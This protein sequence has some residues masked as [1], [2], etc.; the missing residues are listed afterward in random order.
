MTTDQIT[1]GPP[2]DD[3]DR[4]RFAR[5]SEYAFWDEPAINPD[6]GWLDGSGGTVIRLARLGETVIGGALVI[7]AGQWFGGQ[8]VPAALI[9]AVSVAPEHRRGGVGK[10]LVADYLR[11]ARDA[12]LA[13]STLYPASFGLY[14]WAGYEHA[15]TNLRYELPLTTLATMRPPDDG[16]VVREYEGDGALLRAAYDRQARQT[17]GQIRRPEGFWGG[18]LTED[19][20]ALHRYA[21]ERDGEIVGYLIFIQRTSPDGIK[22]IEI[23]DFVATSR[24][25]SRALLGFLATHWANVGTV[26]LWGGIS[27]HRL[28]GL[29]GRGLRPV[30][31]DPWMV[32]ILDLPAALAARGY[33][34]GV[35]AEWQ[36]DYADDQLSENTGRWVVR[37]QG[38]AATVSPGGDGRIRATVRGLSGLFSGAYPAE[39]MADPTYLVGSDDDLASLTLAFAGPSPWMDDHF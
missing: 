21:A 32:R 5:L 6:I 34:A 2:R 15:G 7:P 20:R 18:R 25:A 29:P 38:G 11:V 3:A 36:L 30:D 33:P 28:L 1:H 16:I 37:I 39:V 10:R 24:A 9:G 8:P 23:R 17:S 27:D 19:R 13:I 26:R 12:G 31:V 35:T 14:H 22:L 4:R